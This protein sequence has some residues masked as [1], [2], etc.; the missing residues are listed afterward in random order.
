MKD[1]SQ[2]PPVMYTIKVVIS[3]K[4]CKIETLLL[5]ITNMKRIRTYRIAPFPLT[6][7]D[8]LGHS[9][10]ASLLRCEF[11]YSLAA[12]DNISDDL[13]HYVV[14]LRQQSLLIYFY[15]LYSSSEMDV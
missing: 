13:E 4:Q 1:F 11:S 2:S 8:L 3:R 15:Q 14:S 7:S 5:Q 10:I 6:L 12:V 9:H